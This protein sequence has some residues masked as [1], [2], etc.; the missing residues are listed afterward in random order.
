MKRN[1][2]INILEGQDQEALS[3]LFNKLAEYGLFVV[4]N[5]EL[6]S[7]LPN[8]EANS[9]GPNWLI[10]IF[11]KMGEDP[12]SREYI[13]PENN[14]VWLF[15]EKIGHWFLNPMRKGIPN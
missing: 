11:E 8:L 9:H 4:P 7:W 10:Q 5:G 1:G 12:H 2:G 14:D 13:K 6:E 15:I 3:N